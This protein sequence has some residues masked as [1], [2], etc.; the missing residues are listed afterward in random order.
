MHISSKAQVYKNEIHKTTKGYR[1]F[2]FNSHAAALLNKR[3]R[4]YPLEVDFVGEASDGSFDFD[5]NELA[6]VEQVCRKF[7]GLE[8]APPVKGKKPTH[9]FLLA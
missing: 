9:I 6:Y 3:L 2:A 4:Q 1:V 7:G 5:A 8:T